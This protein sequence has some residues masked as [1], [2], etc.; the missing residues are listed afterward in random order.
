MVCFLGAGSRL[1]ASLCSFP[2]LARGRLV[3]CFCWPG[4][5]GP[6]PC[7][8]AWAWSCLFGGLGVFVRGLRGRAGG[9]VEACGDAFFRGPSGGPEFESRTVSANCRRTYFVTPFLGWIPAPLLG[10]ASGQGPSVR[11][12]LCVDALRTRRRSLREGIGRWGDAFGAGAGVVV[13]LQA[14]PWLFPGRAPRRG[15]GVPAVVGACAR[16]WVGMGGARRNAEQVV[17]REGVVRGLR[18]SGGR[19]RGI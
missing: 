14:R 15:P 12:R 11:R 19:G 5:V 17:E 8:R 3:L 18:A 1:L 6:V 4:L 13:R 7:W 10:P 16:A 2:R 9:G